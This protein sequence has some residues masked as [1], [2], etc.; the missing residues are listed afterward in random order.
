MKDPFIV[1]GCARSGTS[2]TAGII[3]ICGAFGGDMFGPN[4]YN[5][6]GMFENKIIRQDI[7]KPYLRKI[8][9]D[10]LGQKPL[11][12]NR[13]IFEV[14]PNEIK[15]FRTRI[16]LA[17]QNQGYIDGPWFYKGAKACLV[18]YMWHRAFP[19]AK[20]V[21]VRRDTS[22]IIDSCLRTRF[23]KAYNTSEGWKGWV[24]EHKK[25]FSE[26]NIA[27]LDTFEFW[28]S[29]ILDGDIL[30]MR[31]LMEFLALDYDNNSR[32]IEAFIDPKLY[33]RKANGC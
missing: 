10:P 32:M 18:W 7:S 17:I 6:K 5:Q 9:A 21:I 28:P 8:G 30:H 33:R 22:D 19:T 26:M 14:S 25:R 16:V 20:W 11:P 13:Q 15:E 4:S 27:G 1:T 12:N 2:M 31:N 23:M 3:N 29:Q 24:E